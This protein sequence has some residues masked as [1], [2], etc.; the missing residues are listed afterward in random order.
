M[1]RKE[2]LKKTVCLILALCLTL[3]LSACGESRLSTALDIVS[4]A[5]D[6]MKMLTPAPTP[7]PT[8]SPSPAPTAE[9]TPTPMPEPTATPVP[10]PTPRVDTYLTGTA[11]ADYLKYAPVCDT[12]DDEL[13]DKFIAAAESGVSLSYG[14]ADDVSAI[15][16]SVV[17]TES[18]NTN[19]ML[20]CAD[21]SGL[22]DLG[23]FNVL[24]DCDM[25]Y[26]YL[27][28]VNY[29]GCCALSECRPFGGSFLAEP[30]DLIFW[31]DED[32]TAVNFAVV[33][34]AKDS[35]FRI[36]VSRADGTKARF[37][38]NWANLGKKCVEQGVLVHLTYPV[39]EQMVFYFCVNELGYTSAAACGI[40]ANI[41]K[42]SSFRL[43]ARADGSYG[44]CQWLGDRLGTLR[45]WCAANSLDYTALTG[46]LKYMQHELATTKYLDLDFYLMDLGDSAE[47]AY[48]AA[49]E[50]C[51]IFEQPGD[52]A[53]VARDRAEIARDEF[54]PIYSQYQ[55][56]DDTGLQ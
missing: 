41:Y 12:P 13:R 53:N 11:Q 44:L 14:T 43:T 16:E 25:Q 31:L 19:F 30:G 2:R 49:R 42:E 54:Y 6:E 56:N 24:P 10:V 46:Q 34:S 3:C 50:W 40:L 27:T 36:V 8:P 35:Y 9:P 22:T 4:D 21:A 48:N 20:T 29:F 32:G 55:A 39:A 45:N 28:E 51:F 47:D 7:S 1:A 15:L 52:I 18:A 26:H 33:I 37:D 38:V 23:M 17:F 5:A